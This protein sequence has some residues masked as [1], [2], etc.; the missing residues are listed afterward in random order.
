MG[1]ILLAWQHLGLETHE[2]KDIEQKRKDNYRVRENARISK[3]QC[4]M[5]DEECYSVST[6][7][8]YSP[9]EQLREFPI[10]P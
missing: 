5:D 1:G 10:Q 7:D 6:D 4:P 9:P 2:L 8:H 3:Q